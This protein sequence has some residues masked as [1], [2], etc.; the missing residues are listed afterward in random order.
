MN[1]QS[2]VWDCGQGIT[3]TQLLPL[4]GSKYHSA[5][6]FPISCKY[7]EIQLTSSRPA[8]PFINHWM[9]LWGIFMELTILNSTLSDV[10]SYY[11][12]ILQS[13]FLNTDFFA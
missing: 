12:Q 6:N 9:L 11:I 1:I 13:V 4:K 5:D 3:K 8:H 7:Y 10:K 2:G